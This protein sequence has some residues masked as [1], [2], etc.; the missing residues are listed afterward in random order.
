MSKNTPVSSN[1]RKAAKYRGVECLNCGH[2]LDLSD[3]YCPYCS[4]LNSTKQL[5]FTD[6]FAEFINSV[7]S[8]DS[9]LRYTVKDLL[10]KPGTITRNYINGQ[11]LKYANPFR[12]YLSVSIIY[13]ILQSFI[14]LVIP[15][16]DS[17]FNVKTDN[18]DK[19]EQALDNNLFN[20]KIVI[21]KSLQLKKLLQQ[22]P[23]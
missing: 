9:R 7:V 8:Y 16:E 2:P 22:I 4:Q 6:F 5:S 14:T 13:F 19:T 23:F 11:R 18:T 20:F 10:F 12:F 21:I 15:Q 1:S 17:I 3:K